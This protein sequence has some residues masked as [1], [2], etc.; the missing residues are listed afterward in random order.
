[1]SASSTITGTDPNSK[2]QVVVIDDDI[3]VSPT[4]RYAI[5][6]LGKSSDHEI[7]LKKKVD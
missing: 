5:E 4:K 2:H 3:T 7:A 6:I 1:M